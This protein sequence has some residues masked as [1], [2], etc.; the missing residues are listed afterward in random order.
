MFDIS[1]LTSIPCDPT[2][3]LVAE[4][5][6][7]RKQVN[8]LRKSK[9][10][11]EADLALLDSKRRKAVAL[12]KQR[13]KQCEAR[14]QWAVQADELIAKQNKDLAKIKDAAEWI[15]QKARQ[16]ADEMIRLATTEGINI[17]KQFT[18]RGEAIFA[19]AQRDSGPVLEII[20]GLI[21]R[22]EGLCRDKGQVYGDGIAG[23]CYKIPADNV[24][25]LKSLASDLQRRLE[26]YKASKAQPL[27][28]TSNGTAH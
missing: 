1:Q 11:A 5:A 20:E 28:I 22:I 13:E 24:T 15:K 10:K 4:I 23:H 2:A 9:A 27:R 25:L 26:I 21:E 14:R 19:K 16:D 12:V 6:A 3:E 8:S 18:L 17:R 7:L